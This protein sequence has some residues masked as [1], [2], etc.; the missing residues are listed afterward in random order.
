[1]SAPI[2]DGGSA[3]PSVARVI[4]QPHHDGLS[5]RDYFAGQALAGLLSSGIK[6]Q[7]WEETIAFDSYKIADAMLVRREVNP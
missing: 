4:W 6:S 3:F 2:N 7:A 5:L 1:M